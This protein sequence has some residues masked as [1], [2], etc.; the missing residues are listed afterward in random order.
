LNRYPANLHTA[1][2]VLHARLVVSLEISLPCQLVHADLP[3]PVS[4]LT[5]MW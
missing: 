1:V 5:A 2:L 4:Q 3:W